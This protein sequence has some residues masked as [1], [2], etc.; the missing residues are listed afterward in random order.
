M[1]NVTRLFNAQHR[2]KLA[3]QHK[4]S[5][6]GV[7][8]EWG[9]VPFNLM[10]LTFGTLLEI[11]TTLDEG[12][13]VLDRLK[14]AQAQFNAGQVTSDVVDLAGEAL[15]FIAR[16]APELVLL[17]RD[18][19]AKS[20]NVCDQGSEAERADDRAAYEQWFTEQDAIG[21]LRA[22][23]PKFREV[24]GSRPLATPTPAESEAAPS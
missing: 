6:T 7:I 3:K 16:E 12:A 2:A 18:H 10:P 19:M 5:P 23:L 1:S 8:F 4:L 11:T 13:A 17:V 20:P 21:M 9:G 24:I 15:K 14:L 22:L